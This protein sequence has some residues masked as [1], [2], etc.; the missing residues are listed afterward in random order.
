MPYKKLEVDEADKY[1]QDDLNHLT[2]INNK[3][4]FDVTLPNQP[5]IDDFSEGVTHPCF[6]TGLNFMRVNRRIKDGLILEAVSYTHL[7]LPTKA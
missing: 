2:F 6:Y 5:Y 1:S 4:P 7:T 3:I